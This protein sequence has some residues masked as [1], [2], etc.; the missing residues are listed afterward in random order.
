MFFQKICVRGVYDVFN[1]F[2]FYCIFIHKFFEN[3]LPIH[4]SP[5]SH[6]SI[7]GSHVPAVLTSQTKVTLSSRNKHRVIGLPSNVQ[8]LQCWTG[9]MF[10]R[11]NILMSKCSNV[12]MFQ[13]SNVPMFHCSNVPMFICLN[14]QMFKC[15]NVQMFKCFGKLI[16]T[17]KVS[18]SLFSVI[19]V[20]FL[21]H[22]YLSYS[23]YITAYEW[24]LN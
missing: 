15:S 18:I 5:L 12:P 22:I 24:L 2:E 6:V 17:D 16:S 3:F 8:M 1:F 7:F 11:S 20:L 14:V 13:C 10:E 4:I 19:N 23:P 9:Q 21:F